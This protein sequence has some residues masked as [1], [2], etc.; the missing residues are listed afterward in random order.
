MGLVLA[1]LTFVTVFSWFLS[2]G[3][4]GHPM[5]PSLVI[6]AA[7]LFIALLKARV[8]LREFMEVGFAP[9]WVRYATDAW[10]TLFF[11]AL[12]FVHFVVQR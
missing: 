2:T 12:F 11:G 9:A 1:L 6:S 3:G 8:I 7:V 5:T 4:G 10:L